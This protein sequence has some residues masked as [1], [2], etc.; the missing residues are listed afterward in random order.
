MNKKINLKNIVVHAN[1]EQILNYIQPDSIHLTFTS[2]PYFNARDYSKFESYSQYLNF[3]KEIFERIC[4]ITKEG[5]Y[6]IVNTSPV[7]EPRLKRSSQSKRYPIPYDLHYV[8]T[9]IGWEFVDDIVW[10]K[11]EAS[12]KNRIGGFF[13][14]R[15][16]LAYK[17]NAI[18]EMIMVYRKKTDKL[19]DWN[20]RQY[21]K[22]II[23]Q[24][25]VKDDFETNNVWQ[26]S[27]SC[28]SVHSAIFPLELC[29][30]IISYYSMV[31]DLILDPFAGSGT[32]GVSAM[33]LK[34]NFVLIEK[35][36]KYIDR[37]AQKLGPNDIFD[38]IEFKPKIVDIDYFE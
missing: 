4:L 17:P 5:R 11:P 9:S 10:A 2:P 14:H 30:K 23:E 27:P 35:E 7:L 24:S 33:G 37:I 12:V 32:L 22:D 38:T 15:K 26:I 6:C 31:G 25:R 1:A 3:L 28:D 21:P 20:I 36:K 34:R 29:N 18:T 16:P 8:M 19:I 13:Q